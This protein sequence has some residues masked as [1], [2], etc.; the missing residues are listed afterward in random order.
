MT[1]EP[2]ASLFV[3]RAISQLLLVLALV[4]RSWLRQGGALLLDPLYDAELWTEL[5][6]SF[7]GRG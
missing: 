3:S 2:R 6:T 5:A 7:C 4:W 1:L